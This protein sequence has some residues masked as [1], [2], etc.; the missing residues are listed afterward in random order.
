MIKATLGSEKKVQDKERPI[1]NWAY[2][3]VVAVND[4]EKGT[5]L[6]EEHICTKRP[7]TGIPSSEYK[8]IIGKEIKQKVHK[9]A[10]IMENDFK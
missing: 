7:G 8:K 5:I 6:R 10:M 3:S 4:I 2:R 9:N 1:R